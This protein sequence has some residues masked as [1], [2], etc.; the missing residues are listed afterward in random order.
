MPSLSDIRAILID[1]DGVLYIGDQAIDGA[2]DAIRLVVERHIPHRYV[3][4]TTTRSRADL[5]K[6]LNTLGYT[7][8]ADEIW[9][10]P[11]GAVT[12]LRQRGVRSC[13]CV[14]DEA[15]GSEFGEFDVS[16][17]SPD[18]VVIGDVGSAWNYDLVD[19]IARLVMAGAELVALHKGKFWQAADGLKV[20][21][22]AFVAG[23]EYVTGKDATVIG[24]PSPAFFQA[25]ID[26]LNCSAEQVAMIGDD[27]DSDVGGAQRCGMRGI[28]VRTGKYR[29]P[30][31]AAASIVPDATLD[32][33][34]DLPSW[35]SQNAKGDF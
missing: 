35:L 3:T 1:L 30:L 22:G 15:I 19:Q 26:T 13:F 6:K 17:T 27:I 31:V 9:S 34:A 16:D 7:I 5:A 23:V 21:I 10:S 33:I 25:A 24:K 20:D 28:L 8:D 4:N 18:A 2:I 11:C 12:Y 29:E 14:V 32:S